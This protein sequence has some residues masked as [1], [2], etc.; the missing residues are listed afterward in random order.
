MRHQF[1]LETV[2]GTL[3]L[4]Q[5]FMWMALVAFMYR[6]MMKYGRNPEDDALNFAAM[7]SIYFFGAYLSR[8][9]PWISFLSQSVDVAR[10]VIVD[11]LSIVGTAVAVIGGMLTMRLLI[12]RE[13]R[14]P[15]IA[16]GVVSALLPIALHLL[17]NWWL[18]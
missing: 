2:N 17:L 6:R 1:L 7:I 15:W 11:G 10:P 4:M 13:Y 14:W 18:G 12:P 8:A 9:E 16:A 3:F 5:L